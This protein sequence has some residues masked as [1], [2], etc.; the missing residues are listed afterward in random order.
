MGKFQFVWLQNWNGIG[1]SHNWV[2]ISWAHCCKYDTIYCQSVMFEI[3]SPFEADTMY[4][5]T[6]WRWWRRWQSTA[7]AA[8]AVVTHWDPRLCPLSLVRGEEPRSRCCAT[9]EELAA[10]SNQ[11][12][13]TCCSV[14]TWRRRSKHLDTAW[15]RVSWSWLRW[16]WSCLSWVVFAAAAVVPWK[17]VCW[18]VLHLLSCSRCEAAQGRRPHQ[19]NQT[20]NHHLPWLPASSGWHLRIPGRIF[21]YSI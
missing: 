4:K 2:L 7:A 13:V 15:T 19:Q 10:T 17:L 5:C 16:G 18:D 21:T 9:E 14:R 6:G 20:H 1:T 12:T 11:P 8:A 3:F